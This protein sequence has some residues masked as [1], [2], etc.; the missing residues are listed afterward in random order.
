MKILWKSIKKFIYN[1]KLKI[2]SKWKDKKKYLQEYSKDID[3]SMIK[4]EDLAPNE[5]AEK[6]EEYCK[7]LEWAIEN[8]KVCN[9]ALTG[10]YGSG[11]SS[12][13]RTFENQYVKY[14]Y[15]NI[16]LASFYDKYNKN[17]HNNDEVEDEGNLSKYNE[18][19]SHIEKGILQQLFY[20]VDPKSI[21]YTR[22]KKIG[23]ISSLEI[24][25]HMI[26]MT[27]T[28]ILG[29][30]IFDKNK[31][32]NFISVINKL[33][34]IKNNFWDVMLYGTFTILC[35]YIIVTLIKYCKSRLRINSL[36]LKLEKAEVN[37][38]NQSSESIFNRYLD[39]ILYF[40]EATKYNV[41]VIE[42]LDRF[43]N[44]RIFIKL[45][46]LNQLINNYEKINRRIIFV[47]AIKDDM[48]KNDERT[49]FFD[50]IIPVIPIINPSN[51]CD[52]LLEKIN[53]DDT[54]DKV[55]REFI[56]GVS[57]YIE[58]MRM[59]TN[60]ANEYIMYKSML[61]DIS[62]KSENI[63]GLVIYKN[64][65]PTDF[66][67]LQYNRGLVYEAFDNKKNVVESKV[68]DIEYEINSLE[69]KIELSNKESLLNIRELKYSFLS[70]IGNGKIQVV[71][72][73][74]HSIDEFLNDKFDINE[75]VFNKENLS[76]RYYQNGNGRYDKNI[77]IKNI[78]K[79]SGF[80]NTF[81]ERFENIKYKNN[82]EKEELK[83]QIDILRNQISRLKSLKLHQLIN[84][85]G[86]K[87]VL[88]EDII[89][90]KPIVYL[91]RHGKI[92]ETYMNYLTYFYGNNL[93]AKDMDFILNI[94]NFNGYDFDYKLS[95]IDYI[96]SQLNDYEFGQEEILN[97]S[98]L[99]FMLQHE[100]K[101]AKQLEIIMKQ[102]SN[103]EKISIRFIDEFKEYIEGKNEESKFWRIICKSY[104]SFWEDINTNIIYSKEK[105]DS[106]LFNIISCASIES[107]IKL[108]S[109]NNLADYI[110]NSKEF[111]PMASKA[112]IPNVKDII[113]ELDIHF[114]VIEV[115]NVDK[116]LLS[117]IW[118]E[119]FYDI[120]RNIIED[121]LKIRYGK[122]VNYIN[123]NNLTTIKNT[124]DENFNKY[125]EDNI[126]YYINN[127]FL[128]IEENTK[129]DISIIIELLNLDENKLSI[130]IKENI[131]NKEEFELSVIN[132]V[133]NRLWKVILRSKKLKITWDSVIKYYQYANSIDETLIK[134]LNDEL[135]Y[136]KLSQI[137]LED[138]E[139]N[140]K[141]FKA[142]VE[143]EAI[144]DGAFKELI[145]SIEWTYAEYDTSII[146]KEHLKILVENNKLEFNVYN[147][148]SVREHFDDIHIKFIKCNFQK[149]INNIELYETDAGDLYEIL[150]FDSLYLEDI[151]KIISKINLDLQNENILD[152]NLIELI[153][154]ISFWEKINLGNKLYL[155]IFD[156]IDN[157]KKVRL[158]A[159]QSKFLDDDK[160]TQSIEKI[161]DPLK[162]ILIPR[163]REKFDYS[164][165][166]LELATSLENCKYISSKSI[167]KYK[168]GGEYI[169]FNAK[170]K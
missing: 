25:K 135:V 165:G 63:L 23:N 110:Q 133:P 118:D 86:V 137:I 140:T 47:Y 143:C 100:R 39:E 114:N 90:E 92:D 1:K 156:N 109:N 107:I 139:L 77:L 94:R 70:H 8:D 15:L 98:L 38:D 169:Q 5:N 154:T 53:Q 56:N 121:I 151:Q 103:G 31:F 125:I 20:K 28:I 71:S 55:S 65:Y 102:I 138:N 82:A 10:P 136:N 81:Q 80:D 126:E 64:L 58:D 17:I 116:E 119:R 87:D 101:Y 37:I 78:N 105:I 108:N 68:K 2:Q 73:N 152:M 34:K 120:N 16:S 147:Y 35:I 162:K 22:F 150:R 168:A 160:I 12:I 69:S 6:C 163:S 57:V 19:D 67:E 85:F 46:E 83:N 11:K 41:V 127:V 128:E 159:N 4:Y 24:V 93:T 9:I 49:K 170:N 134:Y 104:V 91:L 155:E 123:Q 106:Y 66:S 141:V 166:M 7:A 132:Q 144:N 88:K 111:L 3:F 122:D 45:R 89:K 60:I 131:I 59:L 124:N 146:S 13:L 26:I 18:I 142:I 161:G 29:L 42:D 52:K 61:N 40:F 149:Y 72:I 54:K 99:E 129:E 164:K 148:N 153:Y 157:D 21:P 43:N 36:S 51:S 62:L 74:N 27:I 145:K 14:K 50:F 158:L 117:Y 44:T 113:K 76:Y 84:T 97:F 115:E 32:N 33:I 130:E 75:E 112:F 95:K 79:N 167:G 96:I 48:F 30:Y